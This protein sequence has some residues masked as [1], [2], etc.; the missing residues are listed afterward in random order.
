M[1]AHMG[2]QHR[3]EWAVGILPGVSFHSCKGLRV[4]GLSVR[5]PGVP[6]RHCGDQGCVKVVLRSDL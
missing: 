6:T 3:L 1:D 2:F 5:E 4:K